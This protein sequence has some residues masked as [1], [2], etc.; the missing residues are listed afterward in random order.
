MHFKQR[1][2]NVWIQ[3]KISFRWDYFKVNHFKIIFWDCF[4]LKSK[5]NLYLNLNLNHTLFRCNT[6]LQ[7]CISFMSYCVLSLSLCL[8]TPCLISIREYPPGWEPADNWCLY[9]VYSMCAWFSHWLF[10]AFCSTVRRGQQVFKLHV[11]LNIERWCRVICSQHQHKSI[12]THMCK[13]TISQS[14]CL[15]TSTGRYWTEKKEKKINKP[16]ATLK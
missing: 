6:D 15:T 1:V 3:K 10:G 11:L 9:S 7:Y 14:I 5:C 16:V 12:Q 8:L 4:S 13:H 2:E